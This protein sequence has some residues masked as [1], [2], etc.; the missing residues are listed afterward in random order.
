[1]PVPGQARWCP[2]ADH[3]GLAACA[4]SWHGTASIT[5]DVPRHVTQLPG[6]PTGS[7][8]QHGVQHAGPLRDDAVPPPGVVSQRVR[9]AEA[10][11]QVERRLDRLMDARR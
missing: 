3:P 7:A 11:S 4:A 9:Q 6:L 2:A 8:S 10:A 5:C 1:M